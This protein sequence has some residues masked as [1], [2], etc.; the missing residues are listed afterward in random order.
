[1]L[2]WSGVVEGYTKNQSVRFIKGFSYSWFEVSDLMSEGYIVYSKIK[3]KYKEISEPAHLMSLYKTA[4]KNRFAEI[5][6]DL[7]TDK[8]HLITFDSWKLPSLDNT[9]FMAIV[10]NAPTEVKETL[11]LMLDTPKEMAESLG[12]NV[13]RRRGFQNNPLVCK[14]LGYDP[15]KI[16]VVKLFKEYFSTI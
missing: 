5:A 9:E 4:L 6:K 8:E 12:L 2:D 15:A 13:K 16:N 11:M 10:T 1:M 14:L 7:L 3:E